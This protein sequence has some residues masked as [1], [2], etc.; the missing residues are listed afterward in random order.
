V[1]DT[2]PWRAL[3]KSLER[4]VVRRFPAWKGG[5]SHDPG[6]TLVELFAFLTENLLY[7]SAPAGA[8]R[9]ARAA[10]KGGEA[11]LRVRYFSGKLLDADDFTAE[12]SYVRGKL[13]RRNRWI[14]GSGV[15]SGLDV[16]IGRTKGAARVVVAPGFA[17]DPRGEEIEVPRRITLLLPTKGRAL[18]V[19]AR[20]SER[21]LRPATVAPSSPTKSWTRVEETFQIS[22]AP[23]AS[24]NTVK[25]ARLTRANGKWALDPRFR[26]RRRKP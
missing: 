2:R 10:A 23:T 17:L 5:N 20:Y 16:S 11:L 18:F 12:Q 25:L 21:F 9:R 24:A 8:R 15:V 1:T 3:V 22:L 26:P 7:R 13:R 14:H 4:E 19:L 6:V